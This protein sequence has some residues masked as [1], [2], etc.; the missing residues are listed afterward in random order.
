MQNFTVKLAVLK[1]TTVAHFTGTPGCEHEA[2]NAQH[3][4]EHGD[5]VVLG[6]ASDL[7]TVL[8]LNWHL[9]GETFPRTSDG[10]RRH[11]L[12]SSRAGHLGV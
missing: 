10:V 3:H 11:A 9:F 2:G 4:H 7:T 8:P 12:H 1:E 6:V 5:H